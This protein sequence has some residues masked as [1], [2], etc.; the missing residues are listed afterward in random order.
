MQAYVQQ[1]L[2]YVTPYASAVDNG[3]GMVYDNLVELHDQRAS[4]PTN[5]TGKPSRPICSARCSIRA[6]PVH[7][8]EPSSPEH[9]KFPPLTA[10]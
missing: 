1:M 8:T 4:W 10:T 7:D 2:G 5:S 6:S 3:M 9:R